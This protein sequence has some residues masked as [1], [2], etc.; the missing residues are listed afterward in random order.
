MQEPY[1]AQNEEPVNGEWQSTL[2][3]HWSHRYPK[4][5]TTRRQE[6]PCCGW[7]GSHDSGHG[8]RGSVLFLLSR[9]FEANLLLSATSLSLEGGEQTSS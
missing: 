4:V 1:E 3:H 5:D 9:F 2:Q 7:Q 6:R 8:W